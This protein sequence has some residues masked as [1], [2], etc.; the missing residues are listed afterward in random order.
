MI[1]KKYQLFFFCFHNTLCEKYLSICFCNSLREI[2][3]FQLAFTILYV[4]FCFQFVFNSINVTFFF[5]GGAF[6]SLI[7]SGGAI[8]SLPFVGGA[9]SSLPDRAIEQQS[10]QSRYKQRFIFLFVS[11]FSFYSCFSNRERL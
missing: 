4:K 6:S 9:F 1:H 7:F 10:I 11:F 8:S 3:L 2:F 5:V